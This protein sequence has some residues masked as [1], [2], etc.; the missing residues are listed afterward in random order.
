VDNPARFGASM[1]PKTSLQELASRQGKGMPAYRVT[2]SGPDH[3]KVFEATVV[4]GGR[5]MA[6][7]TGSSKKQAEMAA[8]LQAWSLLTGESDADRSRTS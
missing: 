7:G 4:V 1:D 8:A 5:D 2:D 6:R 3:N